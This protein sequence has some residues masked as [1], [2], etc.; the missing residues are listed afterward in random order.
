[1]KH[2]LLAAVAACAIGAT[3]NAWAATVTPAY[4]Y[5]SATLLDESSPYTLGFAFSL[6]SAT[7][8]DALGLAGAGNKNARGSFLRARL[9]RLDLSLIRG[10]PETS[11]TRPLAQTSRVPPTA[12][13]TVSVA[14]RPPRG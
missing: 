1:M 13:P 14:A 2:L 11:G 8:L 4:E 12:W 10:G 5:T 3:T 6:N 7:T 9:W